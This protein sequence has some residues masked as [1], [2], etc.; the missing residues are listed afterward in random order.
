MS[1][2]STY[3]ATIS[4]EYIIL[5]LTLY[6]SIF[7]YSLKVQCISVRQ[8]LTLCIILQISTCIA[9]FSFFLSH[10]L[11]PNCIHSPP[12]PSHS[13][14]HNYYYGQLKSSPVKWVLW[15]NVG[16]TWEVLGWPDTGGT[17]YWSDLIL[18]WPDTGVTWY[19]DDLVLGWYL[20]HYI[21]TGVT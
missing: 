8:Q 5:I 12:L 1:L 19:W 9:L 15:K 4:L 3:C 2:R 7:I 10:S 18:G 20:W 17:W 21:S 6:A 16:D 14:P 13:P 11:P